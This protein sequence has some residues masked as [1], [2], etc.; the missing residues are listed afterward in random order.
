MSEDKDLE[1]IYEDKYRAKKIWFFI[2]FYFVNHSFYSVKTGR[3][4][5]GEIFG[6]RRLSRHALQSFDLRRDLKFSPVGMRQ[7]FNS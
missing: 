1:I 3:L 6:L 4:F 2:L 5:S 7:N